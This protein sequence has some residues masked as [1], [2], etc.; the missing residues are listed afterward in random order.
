[1]TYFFRQLG[2]S[3]EAEAMDAYLVGMMHHVSDLL[4]EARCDPEKP[5]NFALINGEVVSYEL[6]HECQSFEEAWATACRWL[7]GES[8]VEYLG[9]G[10]YHH[11]ESMSLEGL[12]EKD[13]RVEGKL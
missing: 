10:E 8:N 1:M 6:M 9:T 2:D 4:G 5:I 13:S 7:G 11:S 3:L 12:A